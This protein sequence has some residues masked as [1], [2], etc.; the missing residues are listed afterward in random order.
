LTNADERENREA[1]S[2]KQAGSGHIEFVV[3]AS[4]TRNEGRHPDHLRSYPSQRQRLENV[5]KDSMLRP[6]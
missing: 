4:M 1:G 3:L 2:A 6:T 5:Q